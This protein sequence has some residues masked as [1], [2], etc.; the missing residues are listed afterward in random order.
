MLL[1]KTRG[2]TLEHKSKL[3][4][5]GKFPYRGTL[6]IKTTGEYIIKKYTETSVGETHCKHTLI[7]RGTQ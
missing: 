3:K 6:E 1:S 4:P 7:H 2:K 5:L